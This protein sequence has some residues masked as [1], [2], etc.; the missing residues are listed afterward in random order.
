MCLWHLEK[1]CDAGPARVGSAPIMNVLRQWRWQRPS[2]SP[3]LRAY[4]CPLKPTTSNGCALHSGGFV[5]HHS[6][7]HPAIGHCRP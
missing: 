6:D 5:C 4:V 1:T 2:G 7:R 3:L